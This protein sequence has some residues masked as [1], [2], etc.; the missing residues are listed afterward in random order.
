MPLFFPM[1]GLC[2]LKRDIFFEKNLNWPNQNTD[3]DG[4]YLEFASQFCNNSIFL[5]E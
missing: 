5:Y 2:K 4:I 3:F 1:A